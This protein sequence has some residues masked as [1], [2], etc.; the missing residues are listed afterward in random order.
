MKSVT[1]YYHVDDV[2]RIHKHN[3]TRDYIFQKYSSWAKMNENSSGF[4][5]RENGGVY[6]GFKTPIKRRL[7]NYFRFVLQLA[8]GSKY[9]CTST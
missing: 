5:I 2:Q 9:F 1:R 7:E 6:E 4:N 8:S 3:N